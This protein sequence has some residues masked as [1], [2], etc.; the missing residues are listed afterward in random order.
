MPQTLNSLLSLGQP[1]VTKGKQWN[2]FEV[3]K[4]S[5][6]QMTKTLQNMAQFLNS[7]LFPANCIV[8][9]GD[10]DGQ[11]RVNPIWPVKVPS[12]MFKFEDF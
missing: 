6:P 2:T 10:Q 12:P 3:L 5:S 9:S 1:L 8:T 7:L 4:L 11:H